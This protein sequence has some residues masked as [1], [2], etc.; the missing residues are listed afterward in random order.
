MNKFNMINPINVLS[1]TVQDENKRTDEYIYICKLVTKES[2]LLPY[3][4]LITIKQFIEYK[5]AITSGIDELNIKIE[6]I[7]IYIDYYGFERK[8]I[9]DINSNNE[10]R[11][12]F[13][14]YH[15]A[16]EALIKID[17]EER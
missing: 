16:S 17:L 1:V 13:N 11:E 4:P 9:T 12:I 7:M 6:K 5:Y 8:E 2:V 15:L 14:S 10:I 3:N